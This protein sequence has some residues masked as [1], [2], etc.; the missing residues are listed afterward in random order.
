MTQ[1]EGRVATRPTGTTTEAH[2]SRPA[3][4]WRAWRLRR[5]ARRDLSELLG[6]EYVTTDGVDWHGWWLDRGVPERE[7]HGRELLSSGFVP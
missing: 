6:V 4:T 2:V 3:D 1:E 7:H 5:D